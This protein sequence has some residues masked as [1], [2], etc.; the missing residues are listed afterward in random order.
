MKDD[1]RESRGKC[2]LSAISQPGC[3]RRK[4][5]PT[6]VPF[7]IRHHKRFPSKRIS[8]PSPSPLRTPKLTQGPLRPTSSQHV[9][10]HVACSS[11]AAQ[12]PPLLCPTS[13]A[14]PHKRAV[15]QGWQL[16]LIRQRIHPVPIATGHRHACVRRPPRR[17]GPEALATEARRKQ[18]IRTSAECRCQ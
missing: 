2:M 18:S 15:C 10:T 14:S 5:S 6:S 4:A 3:L 7:P 16:S 17:L 8:R 9:T 11:I 12:L 13:S 1:E